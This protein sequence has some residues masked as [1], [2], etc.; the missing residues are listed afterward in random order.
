[1]IT[2]PGELAFG[3]EGLALLCLHRQESIQ[4]RA[5]AT[6]VLSSA[7]TALAR[8]VAG[9]D[10]PTNLTEAGVARI[11][12]ADETRDGAEIAAGAMDFNRMY[13]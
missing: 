8:T 11:V 2:S 7:T 5:S 6:F 3:A 1:M 13:R 10:E 4:A 12:V 9:R